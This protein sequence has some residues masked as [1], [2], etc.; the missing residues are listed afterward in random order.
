MYGISNHSLVQISYL[1]I[2]AVLY[3]RDRT[4]TIVTDQLASFGAVRTNHDRGRPA[5]VH[6][7][8]DRLDGTSA[9]QLAI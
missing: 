4:H 7:S 2:Y 8:V 1:D 9:G 6:L 5:V 3:V